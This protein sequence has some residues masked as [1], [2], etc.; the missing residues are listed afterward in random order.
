MAP[1]PDL[2]RL[3]PNVEYL[4][5]MSGPGQSRQEL[6][7]LWRERLQ[8]AHRRYLIAKAECARAKAE[9]LDKITPFPDGEFAFRKAHFRLRLPR[10][11][12]SS[13]L[14]PFSPI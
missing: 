13:M 2:Q 11:E 9:Q 8:E 3:R 6:E 10:Y 4:A 5:S 12:S 7:N 1:I 14:W